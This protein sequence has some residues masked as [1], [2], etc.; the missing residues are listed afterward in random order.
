MYFFYYIEISILPFRNVTT[1]N[2]TLPINIILCYKHPK[3]EFAF[4][5]IHWYKS[6]CEKIRN[7]IQM[8]SGF[9]AAAAQK[10]FNFSIFIYIL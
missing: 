10:L 6:M 1:Q 7:I 5:E 2:I 4:Q 3:Y 9:C 8:Q